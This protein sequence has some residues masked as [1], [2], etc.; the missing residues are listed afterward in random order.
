[1]NYNNVMK[2]LMQ[3]QA[4]YRLVLAESLCK[5]NKH[6]ENCFHE[7]GLEVTDLVKLKYENNVS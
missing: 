4:T 5:H 7:A 3:K 1:M 2:S 6:L